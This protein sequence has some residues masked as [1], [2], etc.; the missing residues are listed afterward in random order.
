MEIEIEKLVG[1]KVII[2]YT[3]DFGFY[4]ADLFKQSPYL[5]VEVLELSRNKKSSIDQ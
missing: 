4:C 5:T 3:D 1:T 2:G